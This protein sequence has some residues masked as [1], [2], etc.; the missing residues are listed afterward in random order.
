MNKNEIASILDEIAVLLE[1]NGE[2]FFKV[3]AYQSAA[4][5]LQT[6]DEELGV[7]IGESRLKQVQGIGDALSKKI[8]ILYKTNELKYYNDLKKLVPSGLVEM[9]EIPSLGAKKIKI[10][11]SELKIDNIEKL[12]KAC[13]AGEVKVLDGF[14]KKTEERI[15]LGI[16]TRKAYKKRHLWWRAN[17]IAKPI[18]EGLRSL[19]E[20]DIADCAGS[21]RRG[22]E[23][24]G[25]LDF[26]VASESPIPVMNWFTSRENV[27]EVTAKGETKSSVRFDTGLQADLR[28]VPFEHYYFTLHHFTGSKE[29]NIKMRHRALKLGFSLSEWGLTPEK[30]ITEKPIKEIQ[31]EKDLFEKLE[32]NYIP[33]ELR[34]GRDEIEEA[35][36]G[37]LPHLIEEKAIRGV[38]HNHTTASDGNNT[39]KEM[40]FAAESFGWEYFGIADHSKASF[41]ANGLNEERIEKQIIEINK[42]NNSKTFKIHIFTG[43]EC[44]ILA[45]GTLDLAPSILSQLDYVVVSVHS[46]FSLSEDAQTK[47]IIR[48]IEEPNTTML[49]HL[50]GRLLLRREG[51][52]INEHK[53]IDAAIANGKIIELNA[54]P[55]RLDMDWRLWKHAAA[56]GLLCSINPDA[57][58]TKNLDYIQAGVLTAR[59]GG[60]TED[61]IFN[62]RSLSQVKSYLLNK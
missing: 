20:V 49:G 37:Q 40:T 38:F 53:I 6:M 19:K 24:V 31:S 23:T 15:L 36:K 29:H 44:D 57:H 43:I 32:L 22:M 17:M 39:L 33:P 3:R 56:K 60:L 54:S 25:D 51:Y 59:K 48:A 10:L 16:K 5:T 50:T 34:E 13:R 52:R 4:R 46:S 55:L 11:H 61:N 9:L 42:L 1:L 30:S 47:R 28:V 14:G 2:N 35:G 8:E 27:A 21:L 18:I 12:E 41:Q 26:I 58:N 62:T 45:D 7:V